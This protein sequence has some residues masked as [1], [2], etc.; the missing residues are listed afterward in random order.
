MA[1]TVTMLC[2][3]ALQRAKF[4]GPKIGTLY[5][6]SPGARMALDEYSRTRDNLLGTRDWD[7]A[8]QTV[9]LGA[10]IKTAPAGG[11]GNNPWTSAYPPPDWIYE[12]AY[13]PNT[14]EVKALLPSPIF[15][16]VAMPRYILFEKAND[17]AL[18]QPVILTNLNN[19]FAMIIGRVTDPEQW[20]DANFADALVDALTA[21]FV[22]AMANDANQQVLADRKAQGSA[23]EA[24]AR[25]G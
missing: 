14:I 12:Y 23:A 21:R 5:D 13:P 3:A 6:G 2:N 10:P 20:T 25:Q 15:V 11:Y 4:R 16:P 1:Q 24:N 19:A 8:R 22:E 18:A 7:F 9:S 17:T